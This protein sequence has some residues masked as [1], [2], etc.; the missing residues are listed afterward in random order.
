MEYRGSEY[1]VVPTAHPDGW[2]WTVFLDGTRMRSGNAA[3]RANAVLDAE[4]VI[5]KALNPPKSNPS[6]PDPG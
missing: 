4:R 5:D 6:S 2:K 3:T 1:P